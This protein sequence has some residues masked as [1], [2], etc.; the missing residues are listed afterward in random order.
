MQ[1]IS[2]NR[3]E[4]S[5]Y[6]GVRGSSLNPDDKPIIPVG[7]TPGA[8]GQKYY[9]KTLAKPKAMAPQQNWMTTTAA[10][11]PFSNFF[12]NSIV[13]LESSDL[14]LPATTQINL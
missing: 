10:L 13:P 1:W 2:C 11:Q 3:L 12:T 6:V 8:R 4:P 5:L 7:V 14:P 9:D